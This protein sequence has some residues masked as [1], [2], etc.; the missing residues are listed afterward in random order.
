MAEPKMISPIEVE[1]LEYA[2]PLDVALLFRKGRIFETLFNAFA[3]INNVCLQR[4]KENPDAV[5]MLLHAGVYE[6]F[7]V[8]HNLFID[9]LSRNFKGMGARDF[10]L[11]F[12]LSSGKTSGRGAMLPLMLNSIMESTR[13]VSVNSEASFRKSYYKPIVYEHIYSKNAAQMAAITFRQEAL[14]GE[15]G[16]AEEARDLVDSLEYLANKG[17]DFE[18]KAFGNSTCRDYWKKSKKHPVTLF[19]L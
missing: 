18:Q 11:D 9:A 12:A 5:P 17:F 7:N 19:K 6:A 13:I 16:N 3:H 1:L 10:V 14:Y 4:E 8:E 2:E 15:L